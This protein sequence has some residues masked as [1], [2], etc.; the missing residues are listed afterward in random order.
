MANKTK[1]DYDCSNGMVGVLNPSTSQTLSAYAEA[2]KAYAQPGVLP[3][4]SSSSSSSS[5]YGGILTP[6]VPL[7]Q[8]ATTSEPSVLP[9]LSG[10]SVV[11]AT[12]LPAGTV[13]GITVAC[14]IVLGMAIGGGWFAW[15]EY[16][17]RR[18]QRTVVGDV[19]GDVEDDA[20]Q[21]QQQQQQEPGATPSKHTLDDN[22]ECAFGDVRGPG[23]EDDD[24]DD[25]DGSSDLADEK[26]GGTTRWGR[27]STEKVAIGTMSVRRSGS[28]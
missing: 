11:F 5:S 6:L 16:A 8:Q 20:S 7:S 13:V 28:F 15:T 19:E 26:M 21:Q 17:R 18:R 10:S 14:V 22:F 27:M 3:S 25:E 23:F 1:Q 12:T 2:A 9:D 24:N 4:S